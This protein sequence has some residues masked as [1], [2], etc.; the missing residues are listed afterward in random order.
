MQSVHLNE[1]H[2]KKGDSTTIQKWI[3]HENCEQTIIPPNFIIS[4][5]AMQGYNFLIKF[6]FVLWLINAFVDSYISR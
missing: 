3:I 5:N 4:F 6:Q 1:L 2:S